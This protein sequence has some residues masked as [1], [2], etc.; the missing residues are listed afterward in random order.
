MTEPVSRATVEAF[1]SAYT[2][3]DPH[4]IGAM[5]DDAVEWH[6]TGPCEAI[7]V[8][9]VWRGKDAVIERFTKVVPQILTVKG[10]RIDHL[11]VDGDSSAMFGRITSLLHATDR[12][13]A[14]GFA[15]IAR[16]RNGKVVYFSVINDSFDAAEQFLGHRLNLH[17]TPAL[18][19]SAFVVA[20]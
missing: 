14:H 19:E 2:S 20:V 7:S 6:V 13:I 16:Y 11:L 9:G 12:V 15:Q 8:C 10:I 5:L 1:Y 4:R 18:A 17:E 3:R